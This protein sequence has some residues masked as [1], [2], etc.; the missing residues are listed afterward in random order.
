MKLFKKK[1]NVVEFFGVKVKIIVD[2]RLDK[3]SDQ[4]LFPEQHE[5]GM[6]LISMIDK[7]N[8]NEILNRKK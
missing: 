8:L 5:A 1:S 7:D 2:K 3:Y 6:K 4:I